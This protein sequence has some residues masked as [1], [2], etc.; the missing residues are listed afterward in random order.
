MEVLTGINTLIAVF[1][2][3]CY[4]Y[5][6]FY[7][8]V[9]LLKKPDKAPE[10]QLHR[11]AV[12]ISARNEQ[13]VIAN[14]IE[15]IH[16]QDYPAAYLD[17][18]VVAD[19]CTDGTAEV[20][21]RAGAT[22]WERFDRQKVGKGYALRYLYQRIQKAFPQR[23]YDGYFIFDADNLLDEHYVT[24]MN[25]TFSAGYRIVTSYRNAKNYGDNWISAGQS[26]WFLRESRYLNRARMILGS[27]CAVSGTGFLV[28]ADIF[29]RN[30]GWKHFLLTE[31][32]EFTVDSI[33]S[34]ERVGYCEEA[35]FYDEQPTSLAQ[36]WRQRL[37][38]TKGGLQVFTRY[39]K[40]L[41]KGMLSLK[42]G[43]S[44]CFSCFDMAMV[45]MPA[46]ILTL[47]STF[48]NGAVVV[49]SLLRR[50]QS[51]LL[52]LLPLLKSLLQG[53][54]LLL[55]MGGITLLSEW[56]RIH[57][58]VGRRFVYLLSFPLFIYTYI[59]IAVAALFQKVEWKPIRH[60]CTKTLEQVRRPAEGAVRD[61]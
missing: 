54:G 23:E 37:R 4:A 35:V 58:P 41:L 5:Q 2:V 48:L 27:S 34:G 20:A 60:T 45:T 21:R 22:V 16:R 57:C 1:F 33:L 53:Y 38:W 17:V 49:Y 13:G 61:V 8:L 42:K 46:M 39:G 47:V 6:G 55:L 28:H 12:L 40:A 15:S 50:D 18:Y 52:T 14:L 24:Q 43:F 51:L 11:F 7:L 9:S 56:R 44:H 30:G 10:G 36:S 29:R 59:P 31:D 26:L 25:R 19:N 32:I 3:V